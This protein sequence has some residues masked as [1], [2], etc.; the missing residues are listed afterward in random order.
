MRNHDT[1][2]SAESVLGSLDG[3]SDGTDLVDLEEES[4]ARLELNGLLDELGVGDGQVITNDLAVVGLEEVRPSLPVILSEGVLDGDD[5][6]LL[7][8]GLVEL[9][10]L[11]VVL[12][13]G[14]VEFT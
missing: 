2:A 4:I 7:G 14:L 10:E 5:G 8:E 6:V 12:L 11:L 3:L 1:P 9:S 13:V